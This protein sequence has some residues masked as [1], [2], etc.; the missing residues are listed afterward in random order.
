MNGETLPEQFHIQTYIGYRV[1]LEIALECAGRDKEC[2]LFIHGPERPRHASR[3]V[4]IEGT[5]YN[6]N[7][8]RRQLLRM[9]RQM[10]NAKPEQSF[11]CNSV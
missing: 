5:G 11:G 6:L 1:Q 2:V 8:P 9:Q 7:V 4:A 3:Y 10:Q